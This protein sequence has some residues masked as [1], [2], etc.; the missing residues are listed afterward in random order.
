V[1][2]DLQSADKERAVV[3]WRN[4]FAVFEAALRVVASFMPFRRKNCGTNFRN[5]GAKSI[6]GTLSEVR[7]VG[8]MMPR[9]K[10]LGCYR[11]S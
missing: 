10:N 8:A 1:K 6:A 2:P 7:R 4:L 5:A 11:K 3:A 9:W